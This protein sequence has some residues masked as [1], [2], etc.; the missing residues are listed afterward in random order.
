MK[1]IIIT[2]AGITCAFACKKNTI[3]KTDAP[4]KYYFKIAPVSDDG[5]KTDTTT[6]KLI[7]VN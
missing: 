4:T 6:Y 7:P 5:S 2:I 1:K 3:P